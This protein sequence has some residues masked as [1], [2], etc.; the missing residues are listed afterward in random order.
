M[1]AER[2]G[3]GYVG[4]MK[5]GAVT[6]AMA[7]LAGWVWWAQ[8]ATVGLI[9][10][11]G[12]IGPATAGYMARAVQ[13]AARESMECLVVQ[14]DTPGGLLD[15]TKEIVQTLYEAPVPVIVYVAPASAGATSAG[16]FIT[17]AADV[18]AM[19]P[20][21]T[22]GAAHPVSVGGLGESAS[23]DDVMKQKLENYTISYIETI[24]AKRSRNVE[25][26][27]SAVRDST[28]ITAEKALELGVVDLVAADL[29]ELLRKVEGRE[30]RGRPLRTAGATVTP[31]PMVARERVFQ[32]LWRPEVLFVLMLIAIY[33]ILGELS[34]PGA[35][36]PGVAGGIALLLALYMASVLPV[37]VAGLALIGLALALFLIDVFAPSHGVLT[38]GG[39]IAFG[40]GSLLL[41]DRAGSA[42]RLSLTFV[43]PATALTAGFF[44]FVVGAGLRAQWLPVKVGVETW[45]GRVT[46]ALVP[47][48]ARSGKVMVDGE[49]WNA[50]CET[51]VAAGQ[52]VEIVAVQG[53]TLRVKAVENRGG[54]TVES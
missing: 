45:R 37:N 6:L 9:R 20:N 42:F 52:A 27:R 23:P 50:V 43:V 33:G 14:M 28:S 2:R 49:Y 30:V 51:P 44:L 1:I 32:S 8:G 13:V 18:A 17:L 3:V 36:L 48:D 22:I 25:W 24:A 11:Q 41:F 34:N 39:V 53:L 38:V 46:T 31:I 15:S 29:P 21:T 10:V 5:P 35:I 4:R 47:I 54:S 19:A 26:A 16:C 40:L 7:A 12:A